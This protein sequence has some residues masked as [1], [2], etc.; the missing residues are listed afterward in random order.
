LA[1]HELEVDVPVDHHEIAATLSIPDH[2]QGLVLFA[3]GSG[4]SRF[5]PR[6]NYVADVLR[7]AGLA[8][9]RVDLL[10]VEEERIDSVTNRY[11]FDIPLLASRLKAATD[12]VETTDPLR[13]MRLGYFG[14]STGAAAALIAAAHRASSIGAIVCRG[15]RPDLAEAALPHVSAPTLFIVGETDH[16]VLERNQAALERLGTTQKDLR[17][18]AGAS[19]LFEEAGALQEAAHLAADWFGEF[20]RPQAHAEA[21]SAAW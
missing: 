21:P 2:A 6:N 3:H 12:W 20:L 8:T 13:S 9:L 7:D 17:V 4:S 18:I 19:H 5:S 1:Q 11:R 10:T 14:A 16:P 15:G